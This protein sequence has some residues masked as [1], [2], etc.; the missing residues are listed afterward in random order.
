MST[1]SDKLL[2]SAGSHLHV[3]SAIT[4]KVTAAAVTDSHLI[5]NTL[6]T[7]TAAFPILPPD[8]ARAATAAGC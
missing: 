7:A 2:A 6:S 1:Q 4:A 8:A 3:T 5:T